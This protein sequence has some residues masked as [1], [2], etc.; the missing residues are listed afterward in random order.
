VPLTLRFLPLYAKLCATYA[1][2][3]ATYAKLSVCFTDEV[4]MRCSK[5]L[6][7]RY[8]KVV[9]DEER[10]LLFCDFEV[11]GM[12]FYYYYYFFNLLDLITKKSSLL[13]ACI[14]NARCI[15]DG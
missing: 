9:K 1:K 7:G 5:P 12:F 15:N 14:T 11:F 2:L 13:L 6:R 10:D 3:C 8:V 4:A